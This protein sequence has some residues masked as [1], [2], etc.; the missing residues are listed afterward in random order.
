MWQ[1]AAK[2]A[3]NKGHLRNGVTHLSQSA[4]PLINKALLLE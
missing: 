4:K 2:G 1:K 3:K